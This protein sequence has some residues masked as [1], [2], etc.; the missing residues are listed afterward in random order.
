MRY[1]M[2]F[3]ALITMHVGRLAAQT[4]M[5]V[6]AIDNEQAMRLDSSGS[7]L[8][9][10]D[11]L[12][13]R[14]S[15][16][17]D[18]IRVFSLAEVRKIVFYENNVSSQDVVGISKSIRIYP[19][20]VKDGFMIEGVGENS[21]FTI[22]SMSGQRIIQKKY[23]LGGLVDASFLKSGIYILQI[24]DCFIKYVKE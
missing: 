2:L 14:S 8:F 23:H 9:F 6:I 7:M 3:A 19:N 5:N 10:A 13:I 22:Y 21:Q 18:T 15:L 16:G 17:T 24:G 12:A 1:L 20:P 4:M 11:S